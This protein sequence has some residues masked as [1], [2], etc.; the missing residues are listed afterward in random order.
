MILGGAFDDLL[1]ANNEFASHFE[2]P[3]LPARAARGLAVLLSL[4]HI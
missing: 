2:N 1:E 3:G 4:I